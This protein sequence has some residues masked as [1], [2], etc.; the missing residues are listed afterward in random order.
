MSVTSDLVLPR[1]SCWC[2]R[3]RGGRWGGARCRRRRRRCAHGGACQASW[4][5]SWS[6]RSRHCS[7]STWCCNRRSHTHIAARDFAEMQV[8][9][10]LILQDLKM[11]SCLPVVGV[12]TGAIPVSLQRMFIQIQ[13]WHVY[14][15]WESVSRSDWKCLVKCVCSPEW[16]WGRRTRRRQQS[17]W[18]SVIQRRACL[19]SPKKK[20]NARI[21]QDSKG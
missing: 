18:S 9:F 11:I 16:A 12:S 4:S 21:L 5:L 2:R 20:T 3:S 19:I 15:Q 7:S 17:Q 14:V 13:R 8:I 10:Y 1:R 6:P